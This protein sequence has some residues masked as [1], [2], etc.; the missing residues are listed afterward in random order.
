VPLTAPAY[1]Y[2]TQGDV[3]AI[4]GVAGVSLRLDDDETG[5]LTAVELAYLN[6]TIIPW[7]TSR[8]NIYLMGRYDAAALS[9]SFAVNDFTAIFA[10]LKLSRRRGNP[11][12]EAIKELYDEAVGLLKEIKANQMSLEDVPERTTGSIS[13]RNIHHSRH[14]LRRNRV[15]RLISERTTPSMPVTTDL[16]SE[17]AGSELYWQ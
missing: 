15:E 5:V 1:L 4:Y 16:P 3:E 17:Y 13:W 14:M 10:A 6:A 8:V 7:A 11:A 2:C 12:P 9:S